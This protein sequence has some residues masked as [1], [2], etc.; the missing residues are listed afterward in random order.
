[1][2]EL[3]KKLYYNPLS[4]FQ[5]LDKLYRKAKLIEPKI[6]V[7]NVKEFLAE[8]ETAQITKEVKKNKKFNTIIS[9]SIR[10]NYQIDI[11]Y[12]PNPTLNK[13]YKYLLT[14][15]D[16]YSR[17]VFVEPLKSKT[18]EVVF[19]AIQKLFSENGKPNNL[20]LDEGKEFNYKPFI[21]YCQENDITLWFSDT[22]QENK[23]AIIERFHRTI[24]NTILK[25][26]TFSSKSYINILPD[27]IKNYN[28]TYHNT[29]KNTPSDI[30][31][32]KEKNQQ[33]HKILEKKIKEGDIVRHLIKKKVFDK[34]SSTLTYTKKTYTVSNIDGN[35]YFLDDLTKPFKEQE[36]I[37]AV[38]G[39][40]ESNYD[41]N[42]ADEKRNE[43]IK[44][45]LIREG[46]D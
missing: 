45:R 28:T 43:T 19:N 36:L 40:I 1:M 42:I 14:C 30:W 17:F 26:E 4:G 23:N 34:S 3:L 6:T 24:R 38:G 9:P 39:N 18:G 44:R 16:V 8:Q 46:L 21:E 37:I 31:K 22:E 11:M 13:N 7:K 2:E 32:Q 12:L 15:I 29:V 20:N 10:N 25:Y 35:S 5:S 41:K 33:I 27:L